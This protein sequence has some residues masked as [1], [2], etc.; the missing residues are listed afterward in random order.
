[1]KSKMVNNIHPFWRGTPN[2]SHLLELWICLRKNNDP[3]KV[4][5]SLLTLTSFKTFPPTILAPGDYTC[6]TTT[7]EGRYIDSFAAPITLPW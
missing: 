2:N 7:E 6:M 3:R 4:C 5:A 1:M